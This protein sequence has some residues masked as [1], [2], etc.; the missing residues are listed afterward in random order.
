MAKN[1]FVAEVIFKDFEILKSL[2]K[3]ALE[4]CLFISKS[5][6]SLLLSVLKSCFKFKLNLTLIKLDGQRLERSYNIIMENYLCLPQ[7]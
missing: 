1:S 6:E 4:N 3:T 5:L 2:Y 7:K